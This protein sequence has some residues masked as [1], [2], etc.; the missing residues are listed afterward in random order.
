MAPGDQLA[1]ASCSPQKEMKMNA[2]V[3]VIEGV[4]FN[5]EQPA[6]ATAWVN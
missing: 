2:R 5:A 6:Q 4:S 1:F 3:R